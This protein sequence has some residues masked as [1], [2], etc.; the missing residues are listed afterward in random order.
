M[1]PSPPFFGELLPVTLT[2]Q[3]LE[4]VYITIGNGYNCM[5]LDEYLKF[6]IFFSILAFFIVIAYRGAFHP[7]QTLRTKLGK[8]MWRNASTR[9]VKWSS[10]IFLVVSLLFLTLS[11]VQ[12]SMGT[13]KWRGSSK[14]YSFS[15]FLK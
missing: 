4:K 5:S 1:D 13:F 11:V 15:D 8:S 6:A 10:M 12:L 7:E 9:Q 2:L 3:I 14:R